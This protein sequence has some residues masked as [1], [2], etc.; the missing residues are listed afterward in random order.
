MSGRLFPVMKTLTFHNE[1]E[2]DPASFKY[3]GLSVKEDGSFGMFGTGL[4]YAIAT[5][6]RMGDSIEIVTKGQRFFFELGKLNF[7]G[8][9][10]S[11][12][13]CNGEELGFTTELGKMWEAWM[14]YREL[15]CN[16]QDEGGGVVE[17]DKTDSTTQVIVSGD[18]L[19]D[20]HAKQDTWFIKEGEKPVWESDKLRLFNGSR[21]AYF[22]QGV[23]VG[24]LGEISPYSID[25]KKGISLSEDRL[26]KYGIL[27][28]DKVAGEL[29][30]CTDKMVLRLFIGKHASDFGKTLNFSSG[31]EPSKEF[32]EIC[33]D[34]YKKTGRWVRGTKE[35]LVEQDSSIMESMEED[36]TERESKMLTKASDFLNR[37]G[38]NVNRFPIIK[39]ST[40]GKELL[41]K[42]EGFE[43][44]YLTASAFERGVFDL[45]CTLLEEFAHCDTEYLD[46]SRDLQ[47]WLFRSV[48]TQAEARLD[49]IL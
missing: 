31:V 11:S 33:R 28:N 46:F 21:S 35:L 32:L 14:A 1:T 8:T 23:Y 3:M 18:V 26:D 29:R 44:I 25:F 15:R 41:G 22:Y 36:F 24:N 39:Y 10:F 43:K 6:L 49:E 16:A 27:T 30:G 48:V 42:A 19:A 34:H 40:E 20:I 13:L 9:E 5:L 2:L 7:R 4:K 38:Y 37:A 12:V 47:D 17:G 45:C